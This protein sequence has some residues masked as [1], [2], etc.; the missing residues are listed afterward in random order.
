MKLLCIAAL[1]GLTC[2]CF[3]NYNQYTRD[4]CHALKAKP[5][6]KLDNSKFGALIEGT[7]VNPSGQIFAV[8]FGSNYST[9]QLG[10]IYPEQ[11]LIFKD[12]RLKSFLNAIRFINSTTAFAADAAN[13]HILKLK[14]DP[15]TNLVVESSIF[16]SDP[17]MIQP[18][19][20]V[21]SST[22]YIFTSGMRSIDNN[23]STDG[24]IWVCS[25]SGQ[26]KRLA[27]LG[28]TNGIELS[29]KE[30]Y[31]YVSESYNL[32]RKPIVQKVWRYKVNVHT[33]EI[34]SPALW[35]D[36][37]KFDNS[38]RNDV[39]GMR[40]DV[41]G[42][43]FITRHGKGEV[44]VFNP[45]AENIATISLS[46]PRPTNLE[47]GGLKGSTLF[48]AGQC[49]EFPIEEIGMGCMDSIDLE[50]QGA[51]YSRIS[52]TTPNYKYPSPYHSNMPSNLRV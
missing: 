39:D 11:K 51:G 44:K 42:N 22:G 7:S 9:N 36:F 33:G 37:G 34:S 48:I 16:C 5:Y 31:L 17:T 1:I 19:D 21:L 28:R 8:N 12:D 47:F 35:I 45:N 43:L 41:Y 49:P 18:N 14:I 26:A 15:V 13:H 3:K 24:D 25:P 52:I 27:L 46:F 30:D 40:A 32:F 29:P 4:I 6:I 50:S 20:L 38:S 23:T 2:C 10:Q